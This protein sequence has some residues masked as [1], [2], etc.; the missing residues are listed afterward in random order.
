MGYLVTDVDR[1]HAADVVDELK[2]V[3]GTARLRVLY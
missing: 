2:S 3:P 1:R